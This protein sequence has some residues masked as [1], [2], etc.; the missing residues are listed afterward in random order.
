MNKF[1]FLITTLWYFCQDDLTLLSILSQ[2]DKF[3]EYN[4]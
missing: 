1:R 3:I 4:L 2:T